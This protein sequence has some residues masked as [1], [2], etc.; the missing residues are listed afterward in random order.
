MHGCWSYS[1]RPLN[2]GGDCDSARDSAHIGSCLIWFGAELTRLTPRA[3]DNNT[4]DA[5]PLTAAIFLL[6]GTR[7]PLP[8]F[9]ENA[10]EDLDIVASRPHGLFLYRSAPGRPT[11]PRDS[12]VFLFF[13]H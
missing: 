13:L 8:L 10:D 12:T 6:T 7:T 1:G 5:H 9:L 4:H 11:P 2:L 3:P